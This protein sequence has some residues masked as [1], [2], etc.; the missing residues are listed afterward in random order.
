MHKPAAVCRIRQVISPK[1][2]KVHYS[3]Q[4]IE[5]I[6]IAVQ[7]WRTLGTHFLCA[8][9]LSPRPGKE[10]PR[11]VG[12]PQPTG[13]W[14]PVAAVRWAG[15]RLLLLSQPQPPLLPAE[16]SPHWFTTPSECLG[17][18]YSPL[19]YTVPSL[20]FLLHATDLWWLLSQ[21]AS[22]EIWS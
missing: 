1:G 18:S 21:A 6:V 12:S 13:G 4:N 22:K 19:Y 20:L 9:L 3:P 5:N 11:Q 2:S 16:A 15:A 10:A 8:R 14:G 7:A 17:W